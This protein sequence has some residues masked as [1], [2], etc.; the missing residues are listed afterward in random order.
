[1]AFFN[2]DTIY[3]LFSYRYIVTNPSHQTQQHYQIIDW[4]MC[5]DYNIV[6]GDDAET[7]R[8]I[9][10]LNSYTERQAILLRERYGGDS[11]VPPK[12]L[13]GTFLIILCFKSCLNQ[14]QRFLAIL[15]NN[16]YFCRIHRI[17]SIYLS[18]Q[19]GL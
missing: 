17:T 18:A 7:T 3:L 6:L 2:S 14:P 8:F 16:V 15:E 9:K 12:I 4:L 11:K 5:I 19:T 10:L 13:G 1:M